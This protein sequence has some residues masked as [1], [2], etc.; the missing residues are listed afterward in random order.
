ME[1]LSS[2]MNAY[3]ATYWLCEIRKVTEA[4]GKMWTIAL[5]ARSF[6]KNSM[7]YCMFKYLK[8]IVRAG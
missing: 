5:T 2:H 6:Y 8:C 4:V 7:T 1:F 3:L